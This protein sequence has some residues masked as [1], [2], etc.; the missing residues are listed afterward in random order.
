MV[1]SHFCSV[2]FIFWHSLKT[3]SPYTP[4]LS[5]ANYVVREID[6]PKE[7]IHKHNKVLCNTLYFYLCIFPFQITV[8]Y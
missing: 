4:H 2:L 8:F 3:V 5:V 7:A 6:V 1:Y